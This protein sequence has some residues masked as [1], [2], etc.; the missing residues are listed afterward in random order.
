MGRGEAGRVQAERLGGSEGVRR[1]KR[2]ATV[3]S[4]GPRALGLLGTLAFEGSAHGAVLLGE[5]DMAHRRPLP[6]QRTLCK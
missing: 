4:R 1:S 6:S 5:A 2:V 3:K